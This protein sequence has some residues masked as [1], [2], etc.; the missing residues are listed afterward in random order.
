E[1]TDAFITECSSLSNQLEG[2]LNY[3]LLLKKQRLLK[4]NRLLLTH[5]GNEVINSDEVTFQKL[6]DGLK[7]II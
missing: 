3:E 2:H 7:V 4:T 6:E 5:M 1:N